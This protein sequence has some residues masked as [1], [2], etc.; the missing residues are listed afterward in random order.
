[1]PKKQKPE[2]PVVELE[3]P[4]NLEAIQDFVES[5]Q[6]KMDSMRPL[7]MD[8]Y[9]FEAWSISKMKV[10]QKCPLQFLLKYILKIKVPPEVGGREDSLAADVGS[11]G[12]RI[13]ELVMLDESI[14]NSFAIAKKEFVPSKL[15][16]QQWVDLVEN[17]ETSVLGFKERMEAFA[18]RN[19]IKA[20][21]TE[22]RLAV[23]KN[24]KQC[25]FF[26]KEAYFRGVV[27]LSIHVKANDLVIIDHKT[28]GGD[29]GIRVYSSQLNSYKPLFHHGLVSVNGAQSGIHFIRAQDVQMGQYSTRSEIEGKLV[30]ELEWEISGAVARVEELGF[31]K[32]I[33]GPYCKWCDYASVCKSKQK[34]LKPLEL[35]SKKII[36]IKAI[37]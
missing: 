8:R 13:L 11:S 15:T 35:D 24:W 30:K 32:H 28:G 31:F 18:R 7:R 29:G 23:T 4:E 10:L 34:F 1:M 14:E 27:D 36:P 16:E 37:V 33:A 17:M 6:Q 2:D 9:G 5:I 3:V 22:K 12:H 26:D 21:Y 20:V 25:G 19:P